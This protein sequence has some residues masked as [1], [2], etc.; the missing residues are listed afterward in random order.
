VTRTPSKIRTLAGA[1]IVVTRPSFSA[2]SLARRIHLLQGAVIRLPGLSLR[3][4]ASS[5]SP[6]RKLGHADAFDLCVFNSP[7]AVRYAWREGQPPG[8]AQGAALFA[9]GAGTVAALARRGV[10]AIASPDRSD[11]EGLLA[12]PQLANVAGRRI[13]LVGAAG[14]RELI[15]P[16]LLRRGATV[17]EIHVYERVAPRL[18]RRHFDALA[19]ADN[20]LITLLS[21]AEALG[22]LA[23]LLPALLL[24]RLQR[25]SLVVSS[26]RLAGI[27][28][29]LGFENIFHAASA[30]AADLVHGAVRA[31][32]H[33][34][35]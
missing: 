31:L 15:A 35:L 33:H 27:A 10:V 23:R 1:T 7:A 30:T 13:A 21:S 16:T 18:T 25:Q 14:G 6:L 22:H 5:A 34:R 29:E 17:E 20:P 3:E 28:D 26:E 32:A 2:S 8:I 12:L 4:R 19:Q 11:S 24:Q 9:I